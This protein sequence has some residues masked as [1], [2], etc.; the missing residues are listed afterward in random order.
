MTDTAHGILTALAPEHREH[1]LGFARPVVLPAAVTVFEED[2]PAERFWIIR[3]GRVALDFNIPGSGFAVVETL[4]PG[5]L[6]GW[7][8]L[9]EPYRWH[10][11]ARTRENVEAWEFD[12]AEVR[13]AIEQDAGFG[14]AVTTR[15]AVTIGQRLRACRARL[16]D[17]YAPPSLATNPSGAPR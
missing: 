15:V 8:W 16:L 12:A 10:L 17:M 4:G 1:L 14:L 3:T 9:F 6:L 5:E 2:S 7:S 13:R 11:G